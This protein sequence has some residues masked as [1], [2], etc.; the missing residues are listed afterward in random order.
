VIYFKLLSRYSSEKTVKKN[1]IDTRIADVQLRFESRTSE[2]A[3]FVTASTNSVD[4]IS[5]TYGIQLWGT[6]STSIIEIFQLFPVEDLAHD[7]RRAF[8][9]AEYSYPKGSPNKKELKKKSAATAVNTVPASVHTQM[10]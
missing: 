9:R 4:I 6:A 5:W 8:V 1:T 2:Y 3:E 7:S 10:T